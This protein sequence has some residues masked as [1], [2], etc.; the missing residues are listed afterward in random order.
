MIFI[1]NKNLAN[2]HHFSDIQNILAIFSVLILNLLLQMCTYA[3]G[4]ISIVLN[5]L[6]LEK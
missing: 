5:G 2:F 1:A 6:I 3:N 4:Y